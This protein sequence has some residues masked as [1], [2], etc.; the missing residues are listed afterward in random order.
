MHSSAHWTNQCSHGRHRLFSNTVSC[1]TY[2]GMT[3]PTFFFF[4][5]GRAQT[6][7]CK[8]KFIQLLLTAAHLASLMGVILHALSKTAP[9]SHTGTTYRRQVLIKRREEKYREKRKTTDISSG[10]MSKCLVSHLRP[11]GERVQMKERSLSSSLSSHPFIAAFLVCVRHQAFFFSS[12][13]FC[14]T[15]VI[16]PT[17]YWICT[18]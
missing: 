10:K 18:V 11:Q 6:I 14:Q 9:L 8:F 17:C 13:F 1:K 7:N 5:W 4:F 12:S 3:F 16:T 15:V 2:F